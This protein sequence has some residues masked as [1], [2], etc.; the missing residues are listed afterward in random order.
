VRPLPL[1]WSLLLFAG[2]TFAWAGQPEKKAPGKEVRYDS[3]V[4]EM[5]SRIMGIHWHT[6]VAPERWTFLP[7]E[8]VNDDD[9]LLC[10]VEFYDGTLGVALA[11]Q[12]SEDDRWMIVR[13]LAQ[14]PMIDSLERL[15]RK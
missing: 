5:T 2:L 7:T 3:T 8:D 11:R 6:G 13:K 12:R 1:G 14:A 10:I 4:A 15:R 9:A